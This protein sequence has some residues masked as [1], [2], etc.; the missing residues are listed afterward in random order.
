MTIG[1]LNIIGVAIM[2]AATVSGSIQTAA[3]SQALTDV[4]T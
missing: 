4:V 1:S 2:L 3:M